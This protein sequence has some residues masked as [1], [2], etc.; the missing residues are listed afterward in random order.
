MQLAIFTISNEIDPIDGHSE[1]S[2]DHFRD[3]HAK[4]FFV[5]VC[6]AGFIAFSFFHPA[7]AGI[8]RLPGRGGGTVRGRNSF[9][10][11]HLSLTRFPR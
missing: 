8:V 5:Y 7:P 9:M 6:A 10:I 11:E 2:R 3:M 1:N 4:F